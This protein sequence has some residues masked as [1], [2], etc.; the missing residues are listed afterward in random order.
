MKQK[1]KEMLKSSE[2]N[3]RAA[4]VKK[5]WHNVSDIGDQFFYVQVENEK[6]E[7]IDLPTGRMHYLRLDP[8][9]EKVVSAALI[10]HEHYLI[11][12]NAGMLIKPTHAAPHYAKMV[13]SA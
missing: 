12:N 3:L 8:V 2:E 5:I 9:V 1:I 11:E 13:F 7:M 10:E 6:W 4:G